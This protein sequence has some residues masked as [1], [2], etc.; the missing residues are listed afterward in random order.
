MNTVPDP[1][2]EG[3]ATE[4]GREST[5]LGALLPWGPVAVLFLVYCAGASGRNGGVDASIVL[6]QSR[7]FLDGRISLH[8][9]AVGG[10]G[11][12]G[13]GGLKYSHFGVGCSV[14]WIPF[15]LVGRLLSAVFGH[16]ST[17]QWEDF[18][19]GFSPAFV[20][21]GTLLLL[22]RAWLD[23]GASAA[24]VRAGVWLFGFA[25]MLWPYSK[26][27]GSDLV[28][29]ALILAGVVAARRTVALRGAALAGLFWGLAFLTR[30]QLVSI[31]PALFAW[32]AL[33]GWTRLRTGGRAQG[34]R[35]AAAHSGT[36]LATFMIAVA[37]KLGWN[38]ARF[39]GWM[40]EPYP[41]SE[42]WV[43][44]SASEYLARVTGQLFDTGRGQVWYNAIILA[45]LLASARRWWRHGRDTL[46][47][48]LSCFVGTVAFFALFDFW[49]GGISLGPRLQL[50]VL[51]LGAI[52]WAY[53]P[54]SSI[55][56][57][58]CS[59][60]SAPR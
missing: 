51:P 38:R 33:L 28:M 9:E 5:P 16:F 30:K 27:L 23:A 49:H 56:P 57:G 46:L 60:P 47:L 59:W 43:M 36:A 17:P 34:L 20:S 25:S 45:V 13:L 6:A 44:P 26:L 35:G 42:G 48:F 24:R 41:G 40:L 50:L 55:G 22:A 29:A 32:I 8:P 4:T 31:T 54:T 19:V 7:A 11:A 21:C 3:Q 37:L 52:G 1:E 10:L 14:F 15:L 58:A 53:L 18:V 39:G 2:T 12:E